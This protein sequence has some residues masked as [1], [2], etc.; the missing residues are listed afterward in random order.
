ML[1]IRDSFNIYPDIWDSFNIYPDIR[2]S[3]NIY[4]DVM[5]ALALRRSQYAGEAVKKF[6][7]KS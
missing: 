2:D 5:D 6:S 3:F 1:H 7:K 4:P